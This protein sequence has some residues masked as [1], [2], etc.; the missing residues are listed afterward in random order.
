MSYASYWLNVYYQHT[1]KKNGKC[2]CVI[3]ILCLDA[4]RISI[5]QTIE[6]DNSNN[7]KQI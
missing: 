3:S 5:Q 6:F 2:F 1:F 4:S 7:D